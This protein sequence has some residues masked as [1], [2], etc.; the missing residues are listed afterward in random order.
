MNLAMLMYKHINNNDFNLPILSL[1]H[2]HYTRNRGILIAPQHR[3]TLYSNSFI[4]QAVRLWNNLPT[5]IRN[6]PTATTLKRKLGKYL[7]SNSLR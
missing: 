4:V 2:N 6:A 7:L 1:N 5:N 3:T